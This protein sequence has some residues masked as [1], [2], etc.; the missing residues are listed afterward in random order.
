MSLTKTQIIQETVDYY[1]A[2]VNRRAF[3]GQVC[4]YKTRSGKMC[5]VGRCLSNSDLLK[6]D[7]RSI[8]AICQIYSLDDILKPEY[9]GHSIGFWVGLQKLHDSGQFW[10]R[11]GL[12]EKGE[13]YLNL[14]YSRDRD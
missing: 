13:S 2:D 4:C 12:T 6:G 14:L 8:E 9:R 7:D 10:D 5:A 11:E 3:Q 1:K